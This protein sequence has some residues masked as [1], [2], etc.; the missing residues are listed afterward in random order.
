MTLCASQT[1]YSYEQVLSMEKR[2]L[3]QLEWYLMC[4]LNGK[5]G[6]LPGELGVMNYATNS[7]CSSMIAASTVYIARHTLHCSPFWNETLKLHTGFSESQ[8]PGCAKLLVNS[9][10]GTRTQAEG[11]I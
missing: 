9:H 7:Y 3:G 11:G 6:L 10:G 1:E 5:H 8:L 2:F 4:D